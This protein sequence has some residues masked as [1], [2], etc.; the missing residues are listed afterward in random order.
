MKRLLA[1][2]G[3]ALYFAA[4]LSLAVLPAVEAETFGVS[5]GFGNFAITGNLSM[6]TGK[7]LEIQNDIGLNFNAP[8]Q[9]TLKHTGSLNWGSSNLNNVDLFLYRD[10]AA[11]LRVGAGDAAAPV[12]QT[13][14]VQDVVAG[15]SNT[16]GANLTIAGSRGTGTGIGGDIIFQG[17]VTG[18]TGTA[19]NSLA[20]I[21]SFS[22]AGGGIKLPAAVV[23]SALPTCAA[24]IAGTMR[25]VSDATT[26]TYLGALTGGGAVYA[27]VVCNGSAWV[28]F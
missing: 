9:I 21:G 16:A 19:Q 4:A 25:A 7:Y 10:A 2:L 22:A 5:G 8:G 6:V 14:N 23:V 28:S 26:P 12:A 17:G 27:P 15:T 20:T 13:I 1:Q 18:T 11:T 24:G 3:A